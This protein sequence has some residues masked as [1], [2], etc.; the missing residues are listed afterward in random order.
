ME[1]RGKYWFLS[2]SSQYPFDYKIGDKIYRFQC[3]DAA[4]EA[5]KCPER[6]EEFVGLLGKEAKALGKTLKK[7]EI[8]SD[9]NDV[10]LSILKDILREKFKNHQLAMQLATINEP[11]T[12]DNNYHDIY[13]GLYQGKGQN[14]L[15][16][17]LSDIQIEIKKELGLYTEKEPD[18]VSYKIQ[19]GGIVSFDTE[20]TGLSSKYDDILQITI[21]GQDGSILLSTYIKP[22]NC[23]DWSEAEKVHH[24]TKDMV[25]DAPDAMKVAKIVK[26]IFDNADVITGYNVG[27]DIKMTAA[28]LGYNFIEKEKQIRAKYPDKWNNLVQKTKEELLS[29]TRDYK[30]WKDSN[31]RKIPDILK[32]NILYQELKKDKIDISYLDENTSYLQEIAEKYT[33][34]MTYCDILPLYRKYTKEENIDTSHKLIDACEFLCPSYFAEF[35]AFA[36]DAAADTLATIE[37]AK[38]LCKR[39]PEYFENLGMDPK[40]VLLQK[41]RWGE[42]KL[43]G[44]SSGIVC[45]QVNCQGTISKGF[46]KRLYQQYPA[47]KRDFYKTYDICQEKGIDQFGK[48]KLFTI[49][50]SEDLQVASIY[51]QENNGDYDKT[52]IIYTDVEKLVNSVDRICKQYPDKPIYLP[53]IMTTEIGDYEVIDGIGCG[54]AGEK[55][56]NLGPMFE[57]LQQK[58]LYLLDTQTGRCE[59]IYKEKTLQNNID[60]DLDFEIG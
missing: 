34:N 25:K 41:N 54:K 23:T 47:L 60:E 1:F 7:K 26:K 43:F 28:R 14:H 21:A 24:I 8:R 42:N 4:F 32:E 55:W 46:T 56:K 27:F 40:E 37:V 57:A 17:L 53:C 19:K 13:W 45:H 12:F 20:T 44:I 18:V 11:I 33:P 35:Q 10:K 22:Q 6:A 29:I 30:N 52:G 3:V 2:N 36:H 5:S 38:E 49:I 51:S 31:E 16:K 50:E 48:I 39:K 58:N 59:P 15:G 9:W